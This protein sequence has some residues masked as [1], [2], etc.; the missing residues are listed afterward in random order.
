MTAPVVRIRG[1][2]RAFG[3]QQVLDGLDLDIGDGE[4]VAMLGPLGLG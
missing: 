3:P 2:C 1:L 4:F